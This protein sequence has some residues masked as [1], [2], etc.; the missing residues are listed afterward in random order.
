[1]TMSLDVEAKKKNL[2]GS[3]ILTYCTTQRRKK[4]NKK[5]IFAEQIY[6][7]VYSG[8]GCVCIAIHSGY[9]SFGRP[10]SNSIRS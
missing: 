9:W 6:V 4:K 10:Q 1:M 8:E 5:E 3:V 7:K 2:F